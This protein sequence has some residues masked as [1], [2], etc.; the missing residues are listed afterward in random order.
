MI[1]NKK[2]K[3]ESIITTC[4]TLFVIISYIT[5]I[6]HIQGLLPSPAIVNGSALLLPVILMGYRSAIKYRL[7]LFP[8]RL[9]YFYIY[10]AFLLATL[11]FVNLNSLR[12]S[13]SISRSLFSVLEFAAMTVLSW[14]A[15][16]SMIY[17]ET[18]SSWIMSYGLIATMSSLLV[19]QLLIPAWEWGIGI[20]MSGG[21]NPNQVAFFAF[22]GIVW[23]HHNSIKSKSTRR[24]DVLLYIS[25]FLVLAW[26]MSRSILLSWFILYAILFSYFLISKASLFFL[27][28]PRVSISNLKI[29]IVISLLVTFLFVYLPN[30]EF[31]Q[32]A[33]SFQRIDERFTGVE[34]V[35]SRLEAWRDLWDYFV[36]A[37]LTGAAGWWNASELLPNHPGRAT[38]PHNLYVRLLSE[39]GALGT[40]AVLMYPI[41]I[42]IGLL[43]KTLTAPVLSQQGIMNCFLFAVLISVS[44]GQMFED[45]YL[46]GVF[47][48]SNYIII[49]ILT[50]S[51]N[52]YVRG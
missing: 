33:Q 32:A 31:I 48:Q 20:R 39:V 13:Y 25:S 42:T 9:K 3:F 52:E 2:V 43:A 24:E 34:N 47:D 14:Q 18:D 40:L 46:V 8:K 45:R 38:S 19:G 22:L 35:E 7:G 5:G 41:Y 26:S 21:T 6:I 15:I 10:A 49:F 16:S 36:E 11:V 37:P 17:G 1:L 51:L 27:K 4:A 30:Y 50:L 28:S 44:V 23:A 29:F 12:P